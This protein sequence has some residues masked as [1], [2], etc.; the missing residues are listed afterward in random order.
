MQLLEGAQSSF[1]FNKHHEITQ[2]YS[3]NPTYHPS[4]VNTLIIL[5]TQAKSFYNSQKKKRKDAQVRS[6]PEKTRSLLV[7]AL[8]WC[9]GAAQQALRKS[10]LQ[11]TEHQHNLDLI[12]TSWQAWKIKAHQGLVHPGYQSLPTFQRQVI[13]I[14][15]LG[16][17]ATNRFL[18]LLETI[19]YKSFPQS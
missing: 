15:I 18:W 19:K 4:I 12:S 14:C 17:C 8:S 5:Q 9:E 13:Q 3:G 16:S 10:W 2:R 11:G 6:L 7:S 1:T